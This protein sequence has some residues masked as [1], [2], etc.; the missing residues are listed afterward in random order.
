MARSGVSEGRDLE[1]DL[2]AEILMW[3]GFFT[4]ENKGHTNIFISWLF[5]VRYAFLKFKV[6]NRRAGEVPCLS[7]DTAVDL[8]KKTLREHGV[9]LFAWR[10]GAGGSSVVLVYSGCRSHP[11]FC[12][13]LMRG[14]YRDDR[15]C[16]G[17]VYISGKY[18]PICVGL[19]SLDDNVYEC[20]RRGWRI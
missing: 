5:T 6:S 20:R 10:L 3:K 14:G 19:L 15:R 7:L 8:G 16:R 13:T 9:K 2:K 17:G 12:T 11:P 4:A 18:M 1:W